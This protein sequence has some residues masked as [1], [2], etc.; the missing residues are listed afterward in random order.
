M[1]VLPVRAEQAKSCQITIQRHVLPTKLANMSR[2]LQTVK[3]ISTQ[4]TNK[5][6][7]IIAPGRDVKILVVS[8]GILLLLK[9]RIQ[10]RMQHKQITY[11]KTKD[12]RKLSQSKK[13]GQALKFLSLMV[14]Q[15][16]LPNLQRKKSHRSS[17][18]IQSKI[19][20]LRDMLILVSQLSFPKNSLDEGLCSRKRNN[21]N[22]RK[23]LKKMP[24]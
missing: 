9:L 1:T 6:Y 5:I 11:K 4:N 18:M 2:L 7:L 24:K 13:H 23:N 15:S 12:H 14:N 10:K 17:N 21:S 16:R 22:G 19:R 8:N 3:L 20:I